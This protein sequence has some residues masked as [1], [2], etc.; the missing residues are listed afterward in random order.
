MSELLSLAPELANEC[1]GS[2]DAWGCSLPG[3]NSGE[4]VLHTAS[5]GLSAQE[6]RDT[7]SC[8]GLKLLTPREDNIC[9]INLTNHYTTVYPAVYRMSQ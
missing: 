5:A 3:N 9:E 8:G 2:R 6:W 4:Y 1:A 7:A